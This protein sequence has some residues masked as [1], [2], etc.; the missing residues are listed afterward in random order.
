MEVTKTVKDL[1]YTK[2]H[3]PVHTGF[4]SYLGRD[5]EDDVST[6]FEVI[7]GHIKKLYDNPEFE[8]YD[9][10]VTGHSLG[11]ALAQLMAMKL[12]ASDNF[13]PKNY[14]QAFPVTAITFASP[15][16]GDASFQQASSLLEKAGRLRHIRFSNQGDLVP[17]LP[18]A[19]IL[20]YTQTGVTIHVQDGLKAEI[21]Y[22]NPLKSFLSQMGWNNPLDRHE[23]TDYFERMHLNN[24]ELK[25]KNVENLYQDYLEGQESSTPITESE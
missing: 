8:D 5:K 13:S 12:A 18:P 11:G 1:G 3:I 10:Y 21:G 14:P 24:P 9:L 23:L 17:V 4:N 22:R 6:K 7:V 15:Q 2:D 20:G 25:T 19:A 16:V